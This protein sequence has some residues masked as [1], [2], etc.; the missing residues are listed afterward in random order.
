MS[1]KRDEQTY[2][3]IGAAM[4][5]HKTLGHGFLEAVYQDAMALELKSRA[6]PFQ[7]EVK[8]PV[9]YKGEKLASFYKAD[10]VCFNQVIVELKALMALSGIEESQVINYLKVSGLRKGL[11]INFGSPRLEYKRLVFNLR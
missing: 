10:F 6:V 11:L 7:R 8:F 5:V 1:E 9:L 4:E 2:E 3:V